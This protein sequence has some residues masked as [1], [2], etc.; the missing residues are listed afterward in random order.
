MSSKLN[1]LISH[2]SPGALV[3]QQWLTVNNIQYSLA[4]RYAESGWLNRLSSG[5]YYRPDHSGN[6]RP[7]WTDALNAITQQLDLPVHLAGLTSLTYQGLSHYLQL[8][9][10]QVWVG[11]Q[12]KQSLPKWFR[13]FEEQDWLYCGNHKLTGLIEKEFTTV[14]VKGK[15][16]KVSSPELAAYEVVDAIGKLI[17]F[18]HAAELFQGLVNLS[19]RKLQSILNR[20][21]AIQTNRVFLFLC[22][23]YN[24][25]W[26]K[27]LDES[28]IKLGSGKRQVVTGG[29]YDECY[30]ITVPESLTLKKE[31]NYE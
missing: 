31:N 7:D 15:M 13:E 20:S 22:H 19:P 5:V 17:S 9:K 18:E 12:N 6:I 28:Q 21:H 29:R 26:V 10:E 4:Q 30:K 1:W 14:V 11:V 16:L 3:L 25:Q 8:G 27:R 24:H 2:T 23:Y